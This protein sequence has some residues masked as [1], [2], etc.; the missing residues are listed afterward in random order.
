MCHQCSERP[1]TL[2]C[3]L[4][5]RKGC[6]HLPQLDGH[7]L[8]TENLMRVKIILLLFPLM[9]ILETE[10]LMRVKI[11]LLLFPLILISAK[12]MYKNTLPPKKKHQKKPKQTKEQTKTKKRT[13]P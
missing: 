13:L 4:L 7:F 10:N 5:V 9:L 8:E 12:F 3:S 2:G 6:C 11:I 1:E